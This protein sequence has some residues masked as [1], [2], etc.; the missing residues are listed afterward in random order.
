MSQPTESAYA[1]ELHNMADSPQRKGNCCAR[2][3][4]ACGGALLV[5]M[6]VS[7]A[8]VV[9]L[10]AAYHPVQNFLADAIHEVGSLQSR[11]GS[12]SMRMM[13]LMGVDH[14]W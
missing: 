13:F 2:H 1:T 6:V 11:G 9:A 14:R 12:C 8:A 5:V 10:G 4:M 7:A 3:P